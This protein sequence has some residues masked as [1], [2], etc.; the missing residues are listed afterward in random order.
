M[1]ELFPDDAFRQKF[2]SDNRQCSIQWDNVKTVE[3]IKLIY[4][5]INFDTIYLDVKRED[6]EKMLALL[7][8]KGI[9]KEV[10]NE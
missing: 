8:E 10:N 7:L 3:D 2:K 6:D 4:K 1:K 5:S 9:V